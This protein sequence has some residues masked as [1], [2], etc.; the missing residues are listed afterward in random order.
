MGRLCNGTL[1]V[2][3]L[4]LMGRRSSTDYSPFLDLLILPVSALSCARTFVQNSRL[5]FYCDAKPV[6]LSPAI[7]LVTS[8]TLFKEEANPLLSLFGHWPNRKGGDPIQHKVDGNDKK[9]SSTDRVYTC[10]ISNSDP[11][12]GVLD[13]LTCSGNEHI[14]LKG[15]LPLFKINCIVC[16][17]ISPRDRTAV[18][19]LLTLA[20]THT[21]K[22]Q[23]AISSARTDRALRRFV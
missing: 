1:I 12:S 7:L 2:Y 18:I 16:V 8:P 10:A 5:I 15:E 13:R 6:R 22:D 19:D 11:K 9:C 3:I 20:K 21:F 17:N 14:R 23:T 4:T